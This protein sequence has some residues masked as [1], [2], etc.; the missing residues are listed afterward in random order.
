MS[1]PN[2]GLEVLT[3]VGASMI[4]MGIGGEN[5]AESSPCTPSVGLKYIVA[6]A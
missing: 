6:P 2:S 4:N 3:P 1:D 5:P